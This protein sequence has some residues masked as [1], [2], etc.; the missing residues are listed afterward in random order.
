MPESPD[1]SNNTEPQAVDS[2]TLLA[3]HRKML[4]KHYSMAA[5][6]YKEDVSYR[7][8][9]K[10]DEEFKA[11]EK[12]FLDALTTVC[13]RANVKGHAPLAGSERGQQGKGKN[14]G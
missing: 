3:L 5:D 12:A 6:E 13:E 1:Q 9:C 8:L 14:H 10:H 7:L 2:N 11:A 4:N